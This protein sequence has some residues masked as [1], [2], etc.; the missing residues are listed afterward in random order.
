M[1]SPSQRSRIVLLAL[2]VAV[3]TAV[4]LDLAI[5]GPGRGTTYTVPA[6]SGSDTAAALI[7]SPVKA[8][9]AA[10]RRPAEPLAFKGADGTLVDLG[11]FRGRVVLV[12]L[13]ATWCPPCIA[14][15]PALDA[16]Q[17][18]LGGPG[19]Q[20]VAISL[21]R[22]GAPVAGAWL[23]KAKLSRLAVY[24][25]D[26]ADFPNAMLPT[27]LLLDSRGRVAWKGAGARDWT[28][29]AVTDEIEALMRE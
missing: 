4:A 23:A 25:A 16:L 18:R 1:N 12:N 13:W 27:S 9:P 24:V 21:D 20:V 2:A 10:Q 26:P 14:E 29:A 17:A 5:R 19:F 7:A 6:P 3:L 15:M 8:M 11:A 22:G 28:G